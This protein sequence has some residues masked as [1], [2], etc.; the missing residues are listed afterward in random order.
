[1]K[2]ILSTPPAVPAALDRARRARVIV[3]LTTTEEKGALAN[4][5][6]YT[7][8]TFGGWVPGPFV[9]AGD[10]VEI[11]LVKLLRDTHTE[12]SGGSS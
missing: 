3:E 11:R 12:L 2:A 6:E 5:V 8:W 7:F 1:V 9:R 4:G 10:M